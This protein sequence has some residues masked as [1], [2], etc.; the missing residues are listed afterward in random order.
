MYYHPFGMM[1]PGREYQ[2]QP[3]RFGFN[4]METS[5]DIKGFGNSYTAE[6]WEYDT[7]L[8]R[9]WNIDP[10][11]AIGVSEYSAFLNNPILYSDVLGDTI[12]RPAVMQHTFED[13][14][15]L[16]LY[17]TPLGK[18]LLDEYSKS[19]SENVY[20]YAYDLGKSIKNNRNEG[21]PIMITTNALKLKDNVNEKGELIINNTSLKNWE[22]RQQKL[23]FVNASGFNF[24]TEAAINLVGLNST[25]DDNLK[26]DKYDL[27]FAI[28]HEIYSH[29]K[30]ARSLSGGESAEHR[31]FG[32]YFYTAGMALYDS[33]IVGGSLMVEGSEAWNVFKQIL[34]LKIKNGDGTNRNKIDLKFMNET[35][36]KAK[37]S[38]LKNKKSAK[39]K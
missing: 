36:A 15:K 9:R 14:L 28:Y 38:A 39:N 29:I 33:N 3:S 18:K 21:E 16:V 6:F 26:F 13:P 25:N 8:G 23:K 32:N 5:N 7:R 2:A 12:F 10:K 30:L 20:F 35:E 11:P 17:K 4:G 37:A 34:E 19:A 31:A 24:R 1:M 22:E 27:A